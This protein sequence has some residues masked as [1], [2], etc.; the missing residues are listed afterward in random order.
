MIYMSSVKNK[1]LQLVILTDRYYPDIVG[2][3]EISLY[4]IVQGIKKIEDIEMRVIA[5]SEAIL[6]DTLDFYNDV[7]IKR[8][9]IKLNVSASNMRLKNLKNGILEIFFRFTQITKIPFLFLIGKA[10]LLIK[11]W[12]YYLFKKTNSSFTL[13]IS[14]MVSNLI[15][16]ICSKEN[17]E[18]LDSDFNC[19]INAEPFYQHIRKCGCDVVHA[20]NTRSILRYFESGAQFPSVAVVRDLKFFCPRR[21]IIANS[22]YGSCN[23]CRYQ[24]LDDLPLFQRPFIKKVFEANMAYRLGALKR[25]NIVVCTSPFLQE[26]LHK[27]AGIEARVIPNP[28]K[29]KNNMHN[30][31]RKTKT[32]KNGDKKLLFVGM[33]IY[34]KGV[35]IAI[36]VLDLL[37]K[38]R[39][40]T[41]L[42]IAGQGLLKNLILEKAQVLNIDKHLELLG[43]LDLE[44][45][46]YY[47]QIADVLICPVR[48]PEPFGRVAL[49]AMACGTPVVAYNLG[50]FSDTILD[51]ETGF[52]AAPGNMEDFTSKVKMILLDDNLRKKMSK[53]CLQWAKKEFCV[54]K[55]ARQYLKAYQVAR[56]CYAV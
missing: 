14:L 32:S 3:G 6:E 55:I 37:L 29:L 25:H 52:L 23:E 53:R 33:F 28:V 49:E 42:F 36:D 12:F 21:T 4:H 30:T 20:D 2:G 27:S 41:K 39:I 17:I 43:F 51:G 34:N 11:Y 16:L 7:E 22:S 1:K 5:Q 46:Q 35:D 26:L 44:E 15:S 10:L 38:D 18:Y 9:S 13:K 56:N 45:L 47:Y 48:W 50:G 8:V 40:Q 19:F 24:C 31:K 54:E